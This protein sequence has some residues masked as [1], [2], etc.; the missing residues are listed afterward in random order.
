MLL[1]GGSR[2]SQPSALGGEHCHLLVPP[3]QPR[4]QQLTGR[5]N[6]DPQNSTHTVSVPVI[7]LQSTTAFSLFFKILYLEIEKNTVKYILYFLDWRSL[8]LLMFCS[9]LDVKG[10]YIVTLPVCKVSGYISLLKW[11]LWFFRSLHGW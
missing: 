6:P 7:R 2:G 9:N 1:D 8:P 5:I 3:P 11:L 10:I 4:H